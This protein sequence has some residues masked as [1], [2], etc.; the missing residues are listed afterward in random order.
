MRF[1]SIHFTC[2]NCGAPL[3]FN[4]ATGTLYCDFCHTGTV[5][6]PE[7]TR[8]EEYD[9]HHAL[10]TLAQ[11][12][13]KEIQKEIICSN[14]GV[15]FRLTPYS[16]SSNCPYCGTPA[17]TTF[18]NPITPESILPFVITH[19]E[20][21]T[22]FSK[23]IGSLWFAP[24]ALKKL[25]N[26][27][28]NLIGYYLPYWTYDADTHTKYSGQRGD[29]YYVTVHKRRIVNGKEQ[30]VEVQEARVRWTATSGRVERYFDDVTVEA[31]ESLSRKIL[32][33]LG[34]WDT[35][36]SKPF[37]EHYLSG[38]E[39]EEYSIGLDSSYE[40]AQAKMNV[41]IRRDIRRDIGGDRQQIDHMQTEY[42]D[43]TFKNALFPVWMTHFRFKNKDYY[44]AINGQSGEISGE[45]PYSY[46]KILLL[47][48]SLLALFTAISYYGNFFDTEFKNSFDS[49]YPG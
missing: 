22:I 27:E 38:F 20:A 43:T 10:T 12:T 32:G 31:N 18:N 14:C 41:I 44:Y 30:L 8:I 1:S 21:K 23:W 9:L 11:H 4:P 5:I 24:N 46:T 25:I 42:T 17:I 37:D 28:K 16:V 7:D 33:S 35:S 26:T 34:T 19:T 15:E 13:P 49:Y 36:R 3:R 48:G 6:K 29:I 40:V 47:I 2:T 39:S 45:R